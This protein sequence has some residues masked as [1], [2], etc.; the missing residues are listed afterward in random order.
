MTRTPGRRS[1][2]H[3]AVFTAQTAKDGR[4]A[5]VEKPVRSSEPNKERARH[6][7]CAFP[8]FSEVVQLF[9]SSSSPSFVLNNAAAAETPHETTFSRALFRASFS[10]SPSLLHVFSLVVRPF[11]RAKEP[12]SPSRNSVFTVTESS[13]SSCFA[14]SAL[15]HERRPL[16]EK[17]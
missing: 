9:F 4:A 8:C 15:F 7:A 10:F 16:E 6:H 2:V 5:K 1:E 12:V 17:K 14:S 3:G 11:L 13:A